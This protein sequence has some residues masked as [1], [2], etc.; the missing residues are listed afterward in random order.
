MSKMGRPRLDRPLSVE[1]KAR[2]TQEQ[3]QE[4]LEYCRLNDV[5]KTDVVRKG[6]FLAMGKKK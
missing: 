3:Y 4:L 2:I 6:I 1:V 5:T